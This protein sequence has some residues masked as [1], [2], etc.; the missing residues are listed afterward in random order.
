MISKQKLFGYYMELSVKE[1]VL[2]MLTN[3][4]HRAYYEESQRQYIEGMIADIRAYERKRNDDLGI[5]I[6]S[7]G[8][9]S[10]ITSAA[11]EERER[12]EKAFKAGKITKALISDKQDR[13][14]MLSA[15]G[16]WLI[17]KDDYESLNR[18]LWK[19]TPTEHELLMAYI[20]REKDYYDIADECK[21][22]FESAKKKIQRIR[23]KVIK[24][25]SPEFE[26]HGLNWRYAG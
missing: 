9:M 12:I 10:D 16:E 26:M 1:R 22:E 24:I 25:A 2:Y 19:L 20:S 3:Y 14:M 4:K 23:G 13:D 21:I 5:R 11:A 15:I 7:G 8:S 18:A 6:M 17:M